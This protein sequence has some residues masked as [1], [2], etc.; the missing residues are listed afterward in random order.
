MLANLEGWDGGVLLAGFLLSEDLQKLVK[1]CLCLQKVCSLGSD[2]SQ[3]LSWHLGCPSSL[4][5][6]KGSCIIFNPM[7]VPHP[8]ARVAS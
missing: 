1:F 4:L 5:V 2:P 8:V 3:R 7:Q 6:S